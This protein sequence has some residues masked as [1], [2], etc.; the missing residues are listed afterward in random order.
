[1]PIRCF[2]YLSPPGLFIVLVLVV[3]VVELRCLAHLVYVVGINPGADDHGAAVGDSSGG[4]FP[5]LGVLAG[6]GTAHVTKASLCRGTRDGA[7][8]CTRCA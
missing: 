5:G 1:M 4:G 6:K 7:I 8:Y 3:L 2:T